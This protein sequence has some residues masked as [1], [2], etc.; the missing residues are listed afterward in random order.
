MAGKPRLQ[1]LPLYCGACMP[2]AGLVV[3]N[4]QEHAS[5]L[6]VASGVLLLLSVVFKL[7]LPVRVPWPVICVSCGCGWV[8]VL[9]CVCRQLTP[10]PLMPTPGADAASS[11]RSVPDITRDRTRAGVEAPVCVVVQATC[12]APARWCSSIP[13]RRQQGPGVQPARVLPGA[14]V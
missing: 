13:H 3:D 5:S 7:V 2:L 8:G 12:H 14:T 11:T 10:P 4:L 1:L 6:Q 9:A